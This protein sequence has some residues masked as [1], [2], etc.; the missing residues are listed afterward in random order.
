M[1]S[2]VAGL[3]WHFGRLLQA[4]AD[5]TWVAEPKNHSEPM[6]AAEAQRSLGEVQ[7][8]LSQQANEQHAA[9]LAA[10]AAGDWAVALG[11]AADALA[12]RCGR[13]SSNLRGRESALWMTR[14]CRARRHPDQ[15][16]L[17]LVRGR[18]RL[19]PLLVGEV[20]PLDHTQLPRETVTEVQ[21]A[22]A[23]ATAA[24]ADLSTALE[25]RSSGAGGPA[26]VDDDSPE[27]LYL[28][29]QCSRL[30]CDVLSAIADYQNSAALGHP[31]AAAELEGYVGRLALCSKVCIQS[32]TVEG[33][34]VS[35]HCV[36][37]LTECGS[38]LGE[39]ELLDRKYQQPK[40]P[41]RWRTVATS[42]RYSK[43]REL[44]QRMVASLGGGGR[45][46][47]W[48]GGGSGAA[49]LPAMPPKIL[50]LQ[51][52]TPAQKEARRDALEQLLC[53]MLRQP[54]V[55]L[56]PK[57]WTFLGFDSPTGA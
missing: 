57:F 11:L 39:S 46:A 31:A 45:L 14:R 17:F 35:Y 28:R 48:L 8:Q 7:R 42:Q 15:V 38:Q 52:L 16:G 43:F 24:R 10:G 25:L 51:Q 40:G 19:A 2:L 32:M 9:A 29:G 20:A 23:A 5:M 56:Q 4:E 27:I 18:A 53:G 50:S 12:S 21:V 6:L 30:L 33:D 1:V 54:S 36:A 47:G 49:E 22:D 37:I 55:L 44:H 3:H 34:A 13:E 41:N 26:P